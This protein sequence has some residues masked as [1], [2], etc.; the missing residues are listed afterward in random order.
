MDHRFLCLFLRSNHF[1]PGP[2]TT[3]LLLYLARMQSSPRLYPN[4]HIRGNSPLFMLTPEVPATT[5]I[6]QAILGALEQCPFSSIQEL[7]RPTCIPTTTVHRHLTQP[8]GFVVKH[9]RWVPR[10]LAPLQKRI[11]PLSQLGSSAS[12]GPSNTTV[13]S[14]LSPLTSHGSIFLQT[15][16]KSR[17]AQK[18]TPLKDRGIP[19]KTQK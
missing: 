5:V 11:V 16:S 4:L 17:F 19:S 10:T 12:S 9:L 2:S 8:L 3:N 14:S 18:R 1:R 13:G 6:G 15:M 7:D